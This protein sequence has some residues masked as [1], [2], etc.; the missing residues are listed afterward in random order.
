MKLPK[1]RRY[2]LPAGL[3]DR[4]SSADPRKGEAAI[5]ELSGLPSDA[6]PALLKEPCL[7]CS[8]T[9]PFLRGSIAAII[10]AGVLWAISYFHPGNLAVILAV[11]CYLGAYGQFMYAML[12]ALDAKKRILLRLAAI[13]DT[14]SHSCQIAV[15]LDS[16]AA[17]WLQQDGPIYI[18]S[19]KFYL[20][21]VVFVSSVCHALERLIP[22]IEQSVYDGLNAHQKSM[23]LYPLA[24]PYA[25]VDLS[26]QIIDILGRYDDPKN[27]KNTGR[28]KS[29]A[30]QGAPTANMKRLRDA[31][32][33]ALEM[34]AHRDAEEATA[35]TLLRAADT[36]RTTQSDIL[37]R[38]VASSDNSASDQLLRASSSDLS[39]SGC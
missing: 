22:Q 3:A 16:I 21:N 2:Q 14:W 23:L 1:P 37:L 34:R 35:Q 15:L 5:D 10:A 4:L 24:E 13:I 8:A 27:W 17:I 7:V 19:Q 36:P 32:R 18:R 25:H 20:D 12:L 6:I 33:R 11:A 38:P 28:L 30:Y 26:V 39:D 31:A 29:F 9:V